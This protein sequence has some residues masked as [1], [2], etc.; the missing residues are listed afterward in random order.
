MK[1]S[2]KR[3][4][5]G[6]AIMIVVMLFLVGSMCSCT[7]LGKENRRRLMQLQIGQTREQVINIMGMPHMNEGY[8]SEKGVSREVLY[9]GTGSLTPESELI[10]LVF[11]NGKLIGWGK[12]YYQKEKP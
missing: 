3:R 6:S 8:K 1:I 10:P 7:S 9:Y 4:W 11:E 12:D 2:A 5:A